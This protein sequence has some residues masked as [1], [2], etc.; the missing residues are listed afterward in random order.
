[1]KLTSKYK[2]DINRVGQWPLRPKAFSCIPSPHQ[3][4]S[5][6]SLRNAGLSSRLLRAVTGA[7]ASAVPRRLPGPCARVE[8]GRYRHVGMAQWGYAEEFLALCPDGRPHL[9]PELDEQLLEAELALVVVRTLTDQ[10]V[11]DAV[12]H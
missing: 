3:K 4:K 1:M 7:S 9:G 5:R 2:K 10:V 8:A 12:G 11:Q 6:H